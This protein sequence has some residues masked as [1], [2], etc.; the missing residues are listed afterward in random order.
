MLTNRPPA[1]SQDTPDVYRPASPPP[2]GDVRASPTMLAVRLSRSLRRYGHRRD[3]AEP[4]PWRTAHGET[5]RLRRSAAEHA[6]R[7]MIGRFQLRPRPP[8]YRL[9][10]ATRNGRSSRS[11]TVRA[12]H[13]GDVT[14]EVS[15]TST[16]PDR[17][18]R[19]CRP[20]QP[21]VHPQPVRV[22]RPRR[23]ARRRRNGPPTGRSS[24]AIAAREVVPGSAGASPPSCSGTCS[25]P[26]TR[27]TSCRRWPWP[28]CRRSC[29]AMA[30]RP[31]RCSPWRPRRRSSRAPVPRP[32]ADHHATVGYSRLGDGRPRAPRPA[33]RLTGG[34]VPP[35][36]STSRAPGPWPTTST[37]SGARSSA[38]TSATS[39]STSVGPRLRRPARGRR[40][41]HPVLRGP[42]RTR[43][44]V[45]P[46]RPRQ[47][48]R[49]H[50]PALRL[51]VLAQRRHG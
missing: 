35:A 50:R 22:R 13:R 48:I 40:G 15:A 11:T 49:R 4:S 26:R 32:R 51:R 21:P 47:P 27:A 14:A 46:G 34:D 36:S 37:G 44:R 12:D 10:G 31:S 38:T 20:G 9:D 19:P 28:G 30:A 6:D 2:I 18:T 29:S 7:G 16:R 33:D 17:R 45:A 24:S 8:R 5:Y 3:P 1:V 42:P 39:W 43:P 23:Q 41:R 25:R